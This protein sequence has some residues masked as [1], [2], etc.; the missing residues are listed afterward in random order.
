MATT[1][2]KTTESEESDSSKSPLAPDAPLDS[3]KSPPAQ[4]GQPTQVVG[5]KAG[6]PEKVPLLV[7]ND[8]GTIERKELD[9]KDVPETERLTQPTPTQADVNL[10]NVSSTL[11]G[12][13][14]GSGKIG[15]KEQGIGR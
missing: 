15:G 12:R 14:N 10:S 13:R 9:F 6:E 5:D 11:A 1:N 2:T 3:T 7:R 4:P 8:D